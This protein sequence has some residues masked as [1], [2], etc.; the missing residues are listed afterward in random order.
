MR[1]PLHVGAGLDDVDNNTIL[2][3][4]ASLYGEREE[5]LVEGEVGLGPGPEPAEAG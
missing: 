3:G 5:E 1:V 4:F 2:L